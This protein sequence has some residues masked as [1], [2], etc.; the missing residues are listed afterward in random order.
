MEEY[1]LNNN[2]HRFN[3]PAIKMFNKN[4]TI[5]YEGYYNNG[6]KH[7]SVGPA[8]I[9][10]FNTKKISANQKFETFFFLNGKCIHKNIFLNLLESNLNDN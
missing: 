7:N 9:F 10:Y 3:K 4:G 6:K 5:Y 2:L 8:E 1:Y